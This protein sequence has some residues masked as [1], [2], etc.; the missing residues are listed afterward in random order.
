MTAAAPWQNP[1]ASYSGPVGGGQNHFDLIPQSATPEQRAQ[2]MAMM[3]NVDPATGQQ[4]DYEGQFGKWT[5]DE[6]R[7]SN[8]QNFLGSK[9]LENAAAGHGG[10]LQHHAGQV[11][12]GIMNPL[13]AA[14]GGRM[15]KEAGRLGNRLYDDTFGSLGGWAGE[16]LFGEHGLAG[17]YTRHL[18]NMSAGGAIPGG[19][20]YSGYQAD[21]EATK[22]RGA[23]PRQALGVVGTN[24]GTSIASVGGPLVGGGLAGAG[25]SALGGATSGAAGA[26]GAGKNPLT[27]AAMGVVPGLVGA[28]AGAL[29]GG[30]LSGAVASGAASGATRAALSGDNRTSILESALTGGAAGGVGSAVG[31][32]TDMPMLGSLA[33][34][35][36][37]MGLSSLFS[38]SG[39]GGNMPAGNVNPLMLGPGGNVAAGAGEPGQTMAKPLNTQGPKTAGNVAAGAGGPPPNG[40]PAGHGVDPLGLHDAETAAALADPWAPN[41]YAYMN[42]LNSMMNGGDFTK[43]PSY[44]FRLNQGN[45]QINRNAAATG[46]VGSGKQLAALMQF[47]QGLASEEFGNEE[48]RLE[49]LAGVQS[50][51]PSSAAMSWAMGRQ[52]LQG[53]LGGL[54]GQLVGSGGLGGLLSSVLGGARSAGSGLTGMLSRLFGGGGGGGSVPGGTGDQAFDPTS[55]PAWNQYQDSTPFGAGNTPF[56]EGGQDTWLNPDGSYNNPYTPDFSNQGFDPSIYPSTTGGDASVSID[57]GGYDPS[58]W[59][60]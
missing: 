2:L 41:R 1:W 59:G 32:A 12:G 58:F 39:G 25:V 60:G 3:S 21:Y 40:P 48:Q 57:W 19:G 34:R 53:N 16:H 23:T 15:T 38:N 10:W 22:E 6:M 51:S 50:S 24:L 31:G 30:G 8:I 49:R 14:T 56:W 35:A 33:S 28:G 13:D 4:H 17:N 20:G 7:N 55:D 46:G 43:D 44:Q 29:A 45:E 26:Y 11:L 47:G 5:S 54:L 42:Q 52:N 9:P 18:F 37:G 36:T 27:G